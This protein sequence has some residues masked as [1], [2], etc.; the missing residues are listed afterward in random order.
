MVAILFN[1]T[2]EDLENIRGSINLD[3]IR[4][5]YTD[6]EFENTEG[7]TGKELHEAKVRDLHI[8]RRKYPEKAY[9]LLEK[10]K[11][12]IRDSISETANGT[13]TV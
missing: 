7:L 5:I 4:A 3:L 10:F 9:D 1:E 13:N 8:V 11:R 2:I 6:V 12:L